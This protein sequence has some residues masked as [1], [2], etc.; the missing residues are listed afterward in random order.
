[1]VAARREG[2]HRVHH[3]LRARNFKPPLT[4]LPFSP[5]PSSPLDNVALPCLQTKTSRIEFILRRAV[6][7]PLACEKFGVFSTNTAV[8]ERFRWRTGRPARVQRHSTPVIGIRNIRARCLSYIRSLRG[9]ENGTDGGVS[10]GS[11]YRDCTQVLE[12]DAQLGTTFWSPNIRFRLFCAEGDAWFTFF[13]SHVSNSCAP[14]RVLSQ[15][16]C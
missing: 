11:H 1:M 16:Y 15:G 3:L 5:Q 10:L 8:A 14:A 2:L 9:S 12:C 6:L 7:L 4:L 13:L